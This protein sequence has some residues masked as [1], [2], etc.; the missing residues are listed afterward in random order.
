MSYT[1]TTD[2]SL[3]WCHHQQ[4]ISQ[5]VEAGH[6]ILLE[7]VEKGEEKRGASLPLQIQPQTAIQSLGEKVEA[8]GGYTEIRQNLHS[9]SLLILYKGGGSSTFST[10]GLKPSPRETLTR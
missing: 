8:Q 2:P 4:S 3:I 6:A 1:Q 10:E 5:R 9:Q 7:I